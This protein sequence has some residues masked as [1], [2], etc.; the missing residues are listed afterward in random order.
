[1]AEP[2]TCD[3]CNQVNCLCPKKEKIQMEEGVVGEEKVYTETLI[4]N[5]TDAL[6][7]ADG[8]FIAEMHKK[9]TAKQATHAGYDAAGLDQWIVEEK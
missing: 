6:I 3:G 7:G 1:M 4:Q 8:D 5:I 2:W 9:V